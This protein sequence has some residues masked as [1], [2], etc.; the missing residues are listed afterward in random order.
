[1]SPS[2]GHISEPTMVWDW[3]FLECR[4]ATRQLVPR[5][6][7]FGLH[8][9]LFSAHQHVVHPRSGSLMSAPVWF[10]SDFMLFYNVQPHLACQDCRRV[11]HPRCG[12]PVRAPVWMWFWTT[13]R[14]YQHLS[15][16]GQGKRRLPHPPKDPSGKCSLLFC[17][18]C[19]HGKVSLCTTEK[20]L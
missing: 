14:I 6:T 2:G 7:A 19:N 17:N 12:S 9:V 5:V 18:S 20:I 8:V 4:A 13:L 15:P 16:P 1:M 11:V 3:F 10:L